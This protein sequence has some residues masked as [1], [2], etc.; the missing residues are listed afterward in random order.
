LTVIATSSGPP[1]A[2]DEASRTLLVTIEEVYNITMEMD[3]NTTP[4]MPPGGVAE[5]ILKITNNGNTNDY[6][7]LE[8]PDVP[9]GWFVTL[10]SEGVPLGP[11]QSKEV[12]VTILASPRL[13]ESPS[14][15]YH[16][17]VKG[18]SDGLP[19]D[20]QE[21][22]VSCQVGAVGKIDFM[23]RGDDTIEV[24]PFKKENYNFIFDVVNK[25]NAMDE[26]ILEVSSMSWDPYSV[27]I[28]PTFYPSIQPISQYEVRQVR[29]EVVVPR[30]TPLG[31]YDITVVA[32][33]TLNPASVKTAVVHIK[34]I[35]EDITVQPIKFKRGEDP[36]FKIW[37]LYQVELGEIIYIGVPVSNNGSEVVHD[38]K[39]K[40]YQDGTMVR[41]ENISS[42]GLLKTIVITVQWKAD[43]LGEFTIQA[44]ASMF[45]DSNKEDN[46]VVATIKVVEPSRD[47]SRFGGNLWSL[48]PGKPLFIILVFVVIIGIGMT[49]RYMMGLRG[50]QS[51][52]DLYES[53]YG[54]DLMGEQNGSGPEWKERDK[55]G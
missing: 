25:G 16:F 17:S 52:R 8:V 36:N 55:G 15:K 37:N 29:L 51:T 54:D 44:T 3:V 39:L 47:I 53:I 45:G 14:Q 4:P 34:V 2:Q 21:L 1:G 22:D 49:V 27:G 46:T 42:L 28:D 26:V 40:V 12:T 5:Y 9:D 18:V 38:I 19:D 50:E 23:V 6:V 48:E 35:Q 32:S 11:G 30:D 43:F 31:Y 20:T 24:N 7:S 33:S 41:Q 10:D 13:E